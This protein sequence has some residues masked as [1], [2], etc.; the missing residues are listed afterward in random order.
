MMLIKNLPEE[1]DYTEE[2]LSELLRSA[3]FDYRDDN[4]YVIPR[5]CLV[6]LSCHLGKDKSEFRQK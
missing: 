2:E 3:G 6:S 4:L 1:D 5:S